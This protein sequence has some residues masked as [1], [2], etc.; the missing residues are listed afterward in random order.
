MTERRALANKIGVLSV[1]CSLAFWLWAC[2]FLF[3]PI[4]RR[5]EWILQVMVAFP[6]WIFLWIMGF[7]LALVAARLG[8]RKWASATLLALTSAGIAYWLVST[9]EW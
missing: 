1:F 4:S 3:T 9:I 7:L 2:L 5:P 8:S 6:L